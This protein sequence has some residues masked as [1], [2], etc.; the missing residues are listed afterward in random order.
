MIECMGCWLKRV[1]L[2]GLPKA[3]GKCHAED[4]S[5]LAS[6]ISTEPPYTVWVY[7]AMLHYAVI[8]VCNTAS[9]MCLQI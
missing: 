4:T 3:F 7:Y 2:T 5:M 8:L 1:T 9:T 6:K